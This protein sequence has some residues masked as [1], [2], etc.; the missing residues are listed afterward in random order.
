MLIAVSLWA[1]MHF[2]APVR[3][4]GAIGDVLWEAQRATSQGLAV[5]AHGDRVF[6][7]GLVST[8]VTTSDFVISA[9]NARN[10]KTI[11]SDRA[12]GEIF[13]LAHAGGRLA[14]VGFNDIGRG[15]ILR[16]YDDTKGRLLWAKTGTDT[17]GSVAMTASTVF[18]AGWTLPDVRLLVRAYDAKTGK[19]LWEDQPEP[20][21]S[22]AVAEAGGRLFVGGRPDTGSSRDAWVIRAYHAQSGRLLW[23]E[24]LANL[25]FSALAVE[26]GRLFAV[27]GAFDLP[28]FRLGFLVRAYDA[29][30]GDLIWEDRSGQ[31]GGLASACSPPFDPIP[32]TDFAF[33]V[34]PDAGRLFV[35]G[36][37][38]S[39]I[40]GRFT[41]VVRAYKMR[42]GE[43]LWEHLAEH[44]AVA[45][46]GN[47]STVVASNKRVFVTNRL[48][49][50]PIQPFAFIIQAFDARTGEVEWQEQGEGL[51]SDTALISGRFITIGT[52]DDLNLL[53]RAY[54]A[55]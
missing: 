20:G 37:S 51:I 41:Y 26:G 35:T 10:G 43:L 46:A 48:E 25:S 22:L 53:I 8:S 6:A 7:A 44:G 23:R 11:W 21:Q 33:A 52:T 36:G 49:T 32:C 38:V 5:V 19:L 27:G 16:V 31:F 40:S 1:V 14:A 4:L 3:A 24:Q 12:P 15:F 9:H 50:V 30:R 2:A 34:D 54:D 13:S 17:L 18:A 29:S 47:P 39:H 28:P 45:L 55:K 42:T